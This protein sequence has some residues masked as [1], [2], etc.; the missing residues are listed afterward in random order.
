MTSRRLRQSQ[1]DYAR[2]YALL[3]KTLWAKMVSLFA[4]ARR[5]NKAMLPSGPDIP[6][7]LI[8]L[9]RAYDSIGPPA[10]L[11]KV[12]TVQKSIITTRQTLSQARRKSGGASAS[13]SKRRATHILLKQQPRS[14]LILM[15]QVSS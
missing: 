10:S 2:D 14:V 6:E 1:R 4:G 3:L 7:H 8:F 9:S 11:W 5:P 13:N 15:P 12:L